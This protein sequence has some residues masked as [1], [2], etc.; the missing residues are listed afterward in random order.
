MKIE[1]PESGDPARQLGADRALSEDLLGAS[2]L[3]QNAGKRSLPSA[4]PHD[5]P[6]KHSSRQQRQLR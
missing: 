2:F 6:T 3:A 4:S 1:M 5:K